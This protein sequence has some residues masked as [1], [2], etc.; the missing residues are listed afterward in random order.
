MIATTDRPRSPRPL[1][2]LGDLSPTPA[3]TGEP[4][5]IVERV[6][7]RC[8]SARLLFAQASKT[9][10]RSSWRHDLVGP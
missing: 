9:S 4:D 6:H 10:A 5:R 1:G 8:A 3:R 7:G 2:L